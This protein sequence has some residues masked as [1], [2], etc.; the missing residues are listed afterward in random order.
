MLRKVAF[1]L[2][3]GTI[4]R[5]PEGGSSGSGAG[6]QGASGLGE[7]DHPGVPGSEQVSLGQPLAQHQPLTLRSKSG[8]PQA[9]PGEKVSE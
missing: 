4:L 2:A 8:F 5:A 7:K 3:W 9:S 1:L 6:R